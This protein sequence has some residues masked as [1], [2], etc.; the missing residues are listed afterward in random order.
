MIENDMS[1]KDIP[2]SFK[3]H[4]K[5]ASKILVIDS[6]DDKIFEVMFCRYTNVAQYLLFIL[7]VR[8]PELCQLV[9]K[10]L[11]EVVFENETRR[12]TICQSPESAYIVEILLLVASESR[13]S[14]IWTKYIKVRFILYTIRVVFNIFFFLVKSEI[15]LE[16]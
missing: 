2:P 4:L 7:K 16:T 14:K 13:L 12:E 8:Y 9:V 15:I 6:S 11:V 1:L 5:K 3:H 10:K